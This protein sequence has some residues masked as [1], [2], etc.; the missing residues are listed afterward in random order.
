M[1]LGRGKS[2]ALTTGTS[3]GL[4]GSSEGGVALQ[5][6]PP[7]HP[8]PPSSGQT[9]NLSITL[10]F[11]EINARRKLVGDSCFPPSLLLRNEDA[12]STTTWIS[13]SGSGEINNSISNDVCAQSLSG[14]WLHVTPWT[15]ACQAPLTV[16]FFRQEYWSGLPHS[17]PGNL[18]NP[19]TE[20][21]SPACLLHCRLIL[22][23][24][25]HQGSPMMASVSWA[26][27]CARSHST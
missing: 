25:G 2:W 27:S 16:R 20:L 3:V 10:C 26:P 6:Q 14:V 12:K 18:P 21:S 9:S 23:L 24:L 13:H 7:H 22:L 1:E 5:N 8:L 19:G 17:P 15:V 4:M 11:L